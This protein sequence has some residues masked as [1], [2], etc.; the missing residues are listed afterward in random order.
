MLLLPLLLSLLLLEGEG[1]TA[2]ALVDEGGD[3]GTMN[4]RVDDTG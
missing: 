3:V 2:M 4:R 1:A